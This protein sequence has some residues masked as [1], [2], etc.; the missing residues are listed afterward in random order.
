MTTR[1]K[2]QRRKPHKRQIWILGAAG[3]LIAFSALF[4]LDRLI[5]EE[6][7]LVLV[8]GVDQSYAGEYID[9]AIYQELLARTVKA[10]KRALATVQERLGLHLQ[11]T[12]SLMVRFMDGEP[13]LEISA[14]TDTYDVHGKRAQVISVYVEP[15]LLGMVDLEQVLTHELTHAVF[16]DQLG[17]RY[18]RLPE[19]L[20][21]GFAVW[22]AEQLQEK[23]EITLA[24]QLFAGEP[25][26]AL[27]N[28]LETQPHTLNDYLEDGLFIAYLESAYGTAAVKQAAHLI[29]KGRRPSVVFERLTGRTWEN[30]KASAYAFAKADVATRLTEG[31]Y[32]AYEEA[33]VFG[34]STDCGALVKQLRQ[35]MRTFPRSFLLPN[36]LY[37]RGQCFA[38]LNEHR[39]AMD[40]FEAIVE[41]HPHYG[42]L[43]DDALYGLGASAVEAGA[44]EQALAA[45][46]PLIKHAVFAQTELIADAQYHLSIAFFYLHRLREARSILREA[47]DGGGRYTQQS[48]ELLSRLNQGLGPL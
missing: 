25:L 34:A 19:W 36:T 10:R 20:R 13:G 9:Q 2:P 47:R 33:L 14:R 27:V 3:I 41:D 26:E 48:Q 6:L 32:D 44:Y 17:W 11:E 7:P 18:R 16:R 1:R 35:F 4:Q 40:A 31:G 15:I 29:M 46:E 5:R 30:V 8:D 45:L 37:F 38:F 23:A 42:Y 24:G 22:T 12:D 21:E 43:L 28:G 39:R